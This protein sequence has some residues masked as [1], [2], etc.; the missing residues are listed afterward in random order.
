M[1][2]E[3]NKAAG[4]LLP[5]LRQILQFLTKQGIAMTANVLYGFLCVR[6]LSKPEYAMF[7]VLFGFMGSLTVMLDIGISGTLAPL[8][9]ERI[10]DLSLIADYV[11][12]IRRIAL[13]LYLVVAPV[14][15]VAF[16]LLVQRQHWGYLIV[17]QMCAVLLVTA[18][19]ARVSSS[20]GA[21]LILRRDRARYYRIQIMGSVGSLTLLVVFW[22]THH[23]NVYVGILLNVAQ[24]LFIATSNYRRA[25]QLLGKKGLPSP[26]KEK[27]VFR[28]AMPNMPS[29]IFYSIQG[30]LALMLITFFG[31]SSN[32]V[33]N[34]GALTRLG[35][36]LT[37][38]SQMNPMLVEPFFAKLPVARLKR[39]YLAAAAIAA[40]F[41]ATFSA[42]AFLFPEVFLWIPGPKYG[43]LRFEV[44]LMILSSSI[45]Y[46]SGF[47]WVVHSSR[48]FVYWWNNMAIILLTLAVQTVFAWKLDLSLVRNVLLLNVGSASAS[49]VVTICCGFYGFR[50]GPQKMERTVP[51]MAR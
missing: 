8:I 7:A 36:I 17:V 20:Y 12:S 15:L 22:L 5:K 47:L 48:R 9:G 11:A 2:I 25:R 49:L 19:F 18:W 46:T 6:M 28:L 34:I 44:G 24:I 35:A 41:A 51:E 50:F 32:G 39:T 3:L 42:T 26:Q 14:A 27:Q 30:Q 13:K 40:T 38:F 29:T 33:A 16:V 1:K 37:F 23:L 10:T 4:F 45:Q 31:H 43:N 21:V